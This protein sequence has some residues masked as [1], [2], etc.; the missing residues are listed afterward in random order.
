MGGAEPFAIHFNARVRGMKSALFSRA[1]VEDIFDQQDLSVTVELLLH[2]PYGR[3][4]AEALTRYRGADAIE[5][6]VTR[7]MV[8]TFRKL[9]YRAEGRFRKL[10][11]LF[12]QRW[13]LAAIKSLLRYR[14]Q[15]GKA[16]PAA[17]FPGPT[18][19]V[20]LQQELAE[21]ASMAELVGG[22]SLW[23]PEMCGALVKHVK[24]YEQDHVLIP[25]EEALDRSYFVEN[26][27][28]LEDDSH[29]NCLQLRRLLQIEI[30]RVN[31][32]A[33]FT[34]VS[35]KAPREVITARLMP[36]GTL[37]RRRLSR[38]AEAQGVVELVE[39]L[40]GTMYGELVEIVYQF[41]QT[42]MFSPTER[43]FEL[44]LMR[45]LRRMARRSPL[46]IA[47]LMDYAWL[48]YNEVTNLRLIARGEAR[49][50]PRGRVRKELL[51]V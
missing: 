12:L 26:A 5:D 13:D 50:L 45:E 38:M 2:S 30:D 20:A 39:M 9:A 44:T 27:A 17:L 34:L 23:D 35:A 40:G 46:S 19:T 4:M 22:L 1:R 10:T 14:H 7:N 25:L 3:E 6:A 31:L 43:Y 16:H 41:L 18:L 48:K 33:L 24:A 42:R 8:A 28:R 15:G 21:R 32:R 47:V 51:F 36:Q 11:A 29:E 37:S 49:H